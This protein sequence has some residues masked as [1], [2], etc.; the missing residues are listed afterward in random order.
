MRD[1]VMVKNNYSI[2]S[3]GINSRVYIQWIGNKGDFVLFF[4]WLLPKILLQTV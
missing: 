3:G 2:L 1:M 4:D